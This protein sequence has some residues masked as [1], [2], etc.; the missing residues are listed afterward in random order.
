MMNET[1]L[2]NWKNANLNGLRIKLDEL[3]GLKEHHE[4]RL[5]LINDE[6][7]VISYYIGLREGS[8]DNNIVQ[9]SEKH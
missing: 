8:S 5:K 1:L 2:D 7:E 4:W 6:M 9:E 3:A